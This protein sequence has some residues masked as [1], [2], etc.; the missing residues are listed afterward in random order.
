MQ[1]YA[2]NERETL[3]QNWKLC[4]AFRFQEVKTFLTKKFTTQSWRGC[5]A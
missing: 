5:A 2:S 1:C 4:Y 3:A